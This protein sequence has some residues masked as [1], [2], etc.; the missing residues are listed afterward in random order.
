MRPKDNEELIILRSGC[1]ATGNNSFNSLVGTGSNKHV[2]GLD[3][4]ISL[5][6]S[7][8][9]IVVKHCSFSL[10]AMNEAEVLDAVES[11]FVIVFLILSILSV[12]KFINSLLLNCE[13]IF[14]SGDI[15]LFVNLVTVLN[16]N[17]GLF[18]LLSM[19]LQMCS[20]LAAFR[21][22][23]YLDILFLHGIRKTSKLV[24]LHLRSR[25]RIS[26]LRGLV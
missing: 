12:K 26:F 4:V 20:V 11:T 17:L 13:G 2:V 10:G 25:L 3:A 9:P 16:R 1:S 8:C 18:W 19:S 7:S 23:L 14:R 5:F 24:F 15:C 22:C 21:A 6:S